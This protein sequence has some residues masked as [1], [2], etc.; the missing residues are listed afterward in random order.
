M[1]LAAVAAAAD[2]LPLH[3]VSPHVSSEPKSQPL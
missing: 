3:S 1:E 2:S